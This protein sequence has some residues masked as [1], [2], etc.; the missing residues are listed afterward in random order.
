M[1]IARN[2]NDPRIR[3]PAGLRLRLNRD[4]LVLTLNVVVIVCTCETAWVLQVP[5]AVG[6]GYVGQKARADHPGGSKVVGKYSAVWEGSLGHGVHCGFTNNQ[7]PR[8]LSHKG[9]GTDGVLLESG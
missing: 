8:Q 9:V 1:R 3:Y 7:P 4:F 2:A 5:G 6:T